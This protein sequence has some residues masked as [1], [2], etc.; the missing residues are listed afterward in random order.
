MEDIKQHKSFFGEVKVEG[1]TPSTVTARITDQTVD[2]DNEV[3]LSQGMDAKH[4]LESDPTI[5]F[6]HKYDT[7]PVAKC[8][9]LKKFDD[10]V[11]ATCQFMPRP[12]NHPE[13]AEW[14]P[15]TLFAAYQGGYLSGFS[16]GYKTKKARRAT[17][18]D[19]DKFGPDVER[20]I[21]QYEM[22]EF[23][24]APK[25]ANKNALT[26][27]VSKSL[28]SEE[29]VKTY[30]SDL[31]VKATEEPTEEEVQHA[32]EI[33]EVLEDKPEVVEDKPEES[34]AVKQ[35]VVFFASQK[36]IEKPKVI[37][38]KSLSTAELVAIELKKLR[39]QLR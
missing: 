15:D 38:K 31:E 11:M 16:I 2:H 3:I 32:E 24:V 23:S 7:I 34:K 13:S 25:G 4:F 30:F 20:V 14:L 27:M 6:N 21:E 5:F 10:H 22:F 18:N 39:G 29:E 36:T 28:I 33:A 17:A 26:E 9:S 1:S 8:I 19:R 35:T 37:K 12:E